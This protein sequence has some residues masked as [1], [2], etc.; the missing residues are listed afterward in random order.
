MQTGAARAHLP[1]VL[2]MPHP[3]GRQRPGPGQQQHR[4][5]VEVGVDHP[6]QGVCVGDSA[7][8]RADPDLAAH[9]APALGHA[10]GG[11]LV[12]GVDQ[13]DAGA[14]AGGVHL[15]EAVAAQGG[16]PLDAQARQRLRQKVG[17]VHGST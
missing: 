13:A 4:G 3:G 2:E 15:V 8:D 16:D 7:A 6:G 17:A 14:A 1:E 12:A 5:A 11:L 10:G 9:A